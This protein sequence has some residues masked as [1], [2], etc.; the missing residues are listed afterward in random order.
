MGCCEHG[1]ELSAS[2]TGGIF[3]YWLRVCYRLKK[4]SAVQSWLLIDTIH[5][6]YLNI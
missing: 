1:N 2:V 6:L 3:F 4:E 5:S